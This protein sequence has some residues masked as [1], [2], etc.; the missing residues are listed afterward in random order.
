MLLVGLL[1]TRNMLCG[2]FLPVEI[3]STWVL[4]HDLQPGLIRLPLH[5]HLVSLGQ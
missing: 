5:G 1:G 4:P 3:S 2:C